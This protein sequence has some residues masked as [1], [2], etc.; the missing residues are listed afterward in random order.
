M[1]SKFFNLPGYRNFGNCLSQYMAYF[2]KSKAAATGS[3]VFV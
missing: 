3:T 2:Q 1:G